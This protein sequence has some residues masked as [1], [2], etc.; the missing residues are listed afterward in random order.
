MPFRIMGR[1]EVVVE[2]EEEVGTVDEEE[3]AIWAEEER[4]DDEEG[5]E[6]TELEGGQER[7]EVLGSVARHA[8]RA[9]STVRPAILPPGA[10]Q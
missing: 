10:I 1:L 6:G 8:A 2:E 5:R 3:E 4:E 9:S 7:G